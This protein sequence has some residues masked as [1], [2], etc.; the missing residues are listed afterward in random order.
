MNLYQ[1]AKAVVF[2]SNVHQDIVHVE[3]LLQLDSDDFLADDFSW[4]NAASKT[5]KCLQTIEL[6]SADE[7]YA[8]QEWSSEYDNFINPTALRVVQ[9]PRWTMLTTYAA[10]NTF[11][12]FQQNSALDLSWYGNRSKPITRQDCLNLVTEMTDWVA[13]SSSEEE[14][15]KAGSDLGYVKQRLEELSEALSQECFRHLIYVT[16]EAFGD[17]NRELNAALDMADDYAGMYW[18]AT[19][20][21]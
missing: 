10:K 4:A 9:V 16:F 1:K 8:Y 12:L 13:R 7:L 14:A 17:D 11:S 19:P 20:E 5:Q 2:S 15:I 18:S 3:A 21:D 6:S